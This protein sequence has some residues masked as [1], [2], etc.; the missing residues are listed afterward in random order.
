MAEQVFSKTIENGGWGD[1]ATQKHDF[2]AQDEL[3]V[4]ITLSEY[5]MLVQQQGAYEKRLDE[6]DQEKNRLLSENQKLKQVIET[7]REGLGEDGEE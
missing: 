2:A 6:K 5:R 4:T 1:T 7:L 3:L